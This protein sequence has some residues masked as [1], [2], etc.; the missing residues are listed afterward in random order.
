MQSCDVLI[1]GGGPA[2][3]SCAG[4]LRTSGVD[5]L[6][7]DK[8]TF[9]RMKPCAGWITPQVVS[10]LGLDVEEY[11][12]GG[13]RVFQPLTGFRT[14]LVGGREIETHYGR[15]VSFGIRRC[16][17][18][19]YLLDRSGARVRLGESVRSFERSAGRW[20]V[21]GEIETR[22]LVGAGGHFC[23][24]AARLGARQDPS[25]SVV[26]AQEI[27]FEAS[28]EGLARGTVE[29]EVPEL[30]FCDDMQ[31]YGWCFRKG[32]FLNIGLGRLDTHG[33][34]KHVAQFADFLRQ[35]GKVACDIPARFHGHAYQLYERVAPK[36]IDDGMLL[37]G[38]AA[39][40]AYA[41]SGEG[42]RPAIESGLLAADV[43]LSVAKQGQQADFTVERLAPYAA[44]IKQRFGAPQ[45][46]GPTDWLPAPLMNFLGAKL[47]ASRWF[48]RHVILDRWFLHAAEPALAS[49]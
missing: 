28:A 26:A 6:V 5:V 10:T 15:P 29:A 14:G 8:K 40:F 21:N 34:S 30:F 13:K 18:D 23:P 33:L 1:V 19:G 16:E 42:I 25:A 20:I 27:E 43:I 17:F 24:I 45:S 38:D 2:G 48:S 35:R 49:A 4:K 12:A 41:H 32:N 47:F 7:L 3:S 44:R 46:T 36:L 31:G 9:P 22:M 39:G 11:I 37:I